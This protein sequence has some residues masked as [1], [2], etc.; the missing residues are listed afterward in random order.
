MKLPKVEYQQTLDD[1]GL[2]RALTSFTTPEH[3]KFEKFLNEKNLSI[4]DT[5]FEFLWRDRCDSR[6]VS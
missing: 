2:P 4:R 5:G 3:G 6:Q 1:F